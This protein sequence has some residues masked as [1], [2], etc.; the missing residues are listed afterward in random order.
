MRKWQRGDRDQARYDANKVV[1]H[2][3]GIPE[4]GCA[5]RHDG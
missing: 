5:C 1:V 2:V 3:A 4:G